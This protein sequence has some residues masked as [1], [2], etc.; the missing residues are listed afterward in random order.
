[1]MYSKIW[2]NGHMIINNHLVQL[3]VY[4]FLEKYTLHTSIRR[5]RRMLKEPA[6]AHVALVKLQM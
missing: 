1:M 5:N 6:K 3:K 2:L 4:V